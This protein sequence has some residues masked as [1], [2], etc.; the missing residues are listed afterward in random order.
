MHLLKASLQ[1]VVLLQVCFLH[2]RDSMQSRLTWHVVLERDLLGS[3]DVGNNYIS[4][5]A[6]CG[7][8]T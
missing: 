4:C 3:Y 6:F 8:W 5:I 2:V 7:A 1:S